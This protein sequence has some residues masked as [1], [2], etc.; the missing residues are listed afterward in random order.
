MGWSPE[1]HFNAGRNEWYL[2]WQRKRYHLCSGRGNYAQA[3]T[4][5][6]E[7][8]GLPSLSET[9]A[10]PQRSPAKPATVTELIARWVNIH[11]PSAWTRNMLKSWHIAF[12]TTDLREVDA[13][14]LTRYW[15]WLES[16]PA[17][18]DRAKPQFRNHEPRPQS[19][20]TVAAKV[21]AARRVLQ[22][23]RRRGWAPEQ[24][25]PKLRQV[26][27]E[28]RDYRPDQIAVLWHRLCAAKHRRLAVPAIGFVGETG[29]RPGEVVGMEWSDVDLAAGEVTLYAHKT[30]HST[31]ESRVIPLTPAARAILEQSPRREGYV[32]LSRLAKP[33]TVSGLRSI[34]RRAAKSVGLKLGRLYS[35]RHTRAQSMLESGCS[36]EE[37]AAQLGQRDLNITKRYAQV[38]RAQA[39]EVASRLPSTFQ[40]RT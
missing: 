7:I 18:W 33:Y 23:A 19:A 3:A 40:P 25:V 20:R 37:V 28:P 21:K 27:L 15:A 13:D 22:W 10:E 14:H 5:A 16:H 9:P 26:N 24:T 29:A 31:G 32:F 35:L 4:R 38:R 30:R 34:I 39:R 8:M 6:R 11:A 36:L 12:G 2:Q 1:P 17:E